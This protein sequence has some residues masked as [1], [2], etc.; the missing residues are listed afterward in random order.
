MDPVIVGKEL[1][2]G[3]VPLERYIVA[4]TEAAFWREKTMAICQTQETGLRELERIVLDAD[5]RRAE[6]DID[7]AVQLWL[8][9]GRWLDRWHP[10]EE[11]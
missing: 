6:P 10:E 2:E 11:A 5:V 9:V 3:P 4:A 1:L 7:E 8:A